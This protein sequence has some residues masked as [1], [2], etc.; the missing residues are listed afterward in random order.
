[1][2]PLKQRHFNLLTINIKVQAINMNF[3]EA[4]CICV[5]KT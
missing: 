4:S 1:M 3:I 2:L 5:G